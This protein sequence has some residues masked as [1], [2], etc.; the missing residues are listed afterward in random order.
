MTSKPTREAISG[1][2]RAAT[3]W[4]GSGV[5]RD[6]GVDKEMDEHPHSAPG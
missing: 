2:V 3:S 6:A 1:L 4:V 5:P